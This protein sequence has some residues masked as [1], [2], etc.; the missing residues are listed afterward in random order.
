M[1][2][3]KFLSVILIIVLFNSTVSAEILSWPCGES[4]TLTLNTESGHA[5]VS[6][7][8]EM[9]TN[10][11]LG[12]A[13]ANAWGG[14]CNSFKSVEIQE[15]ITSIGD[16]AFQATSIESI[17][18]PNS[19]TKIGV[20]AFYA[21]P[22]LSSIDIPNSVESIGAWALASTGLKNLVI[23]DSVT[24][25]GYSA[26]NSVAFQTLTIPDTLSLQNICANGVCGS[27]SGVFSSSIKNVICAG[28]GDTEKCDA[29]LKQGGKEIQS[30]SRPNYQLDENGKIIG[31]YEYDA[32]G[33]L[34][35]YTQQ[36]DDG[37]LYS[38]DKN[39]KL[40]GIEGKRIFT[41]EEASALVKDNKNTFKLKYR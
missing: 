8:G 13:N 15:G 25:L 12:V 5:V 29:V 36:K 4:C 38:Y 20:Q 10:N 21:S 1:K 14:Y 17:V 30:I 24:E 11:R 2:K 18:I 40:I 35:Q 22:K 34:K 3:S 27:V 6:G 37:S 16:G 9:V 23:P 41:V 7:Y 39:G 26:L 28:G 31:R 19:V 32:D 33:N